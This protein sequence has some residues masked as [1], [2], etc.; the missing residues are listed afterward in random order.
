MKSLTEKQ[1]EYLDFLMFF[2]EENGYAPRY[3]ELGYHFGVSIKTVSDHLR[4]IEKKGY[5]A[6][7][8]IKNCRCISVLANC[9]KEPVRLRFCVRK[10]GI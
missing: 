5:I 1:K 6:I 10:V 8:G 9:K 3:R 2:I 7:D 4:Y